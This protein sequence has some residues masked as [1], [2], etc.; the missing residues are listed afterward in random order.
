MPDPAFR[1]FSG[2]KIPLKQQNN[3]GDDLKPRGSLSMYDLE[4]I[5]AVHACAQTTGPFERTLAGVSEAHA[6]A[7][8]LIQCSASVQVNGCLGPSA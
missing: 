8:L 1:L 6:C 2:G 3:I 5:L 7:W 4:C